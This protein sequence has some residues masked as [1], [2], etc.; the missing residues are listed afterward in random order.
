MTVVSAVVIVV[1]SLT[2]VT[3]PLWLSTKE[4]CTSISPAD[5]VTKRTSSDVEVNRSM[6]M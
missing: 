1:F 3:T 2:G 4:A 5:A 6:D